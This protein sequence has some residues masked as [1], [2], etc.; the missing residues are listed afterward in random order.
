MNNTMANIKLMSIPAGTFF[1]L[2][3]VTDVTLSAAGRQAGVSVLKRVVGTFRTGISYKNTQKARAYLGD[4]DPSQLPWGK[5]KDGCINRIICHTGKDGQYKEYARLYSTPNKVKTQ[6]Y[7]NGKPI[8]KRELAL[9]G[10][11]PRSY[12]ED[13]VDRGVYTVMLNNIESIG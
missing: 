12:F 6:H 1:K 5:W 9:T 11:V 13:H 4:S 2:S 3:Y 8:S 10:Y 7:L